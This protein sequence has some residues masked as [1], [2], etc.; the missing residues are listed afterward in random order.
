[1]SHEKPRRQ[2]SLSPPGS[3]GRDSP[4]PD[5]RLSRRAQVDGDDSKRPDKNYRRY[6]AGIERTLTLF[7]ATRL[8]WPDYISFL[9]RL[10]KAIQAHPPGTDTLPHK[11]SVALRLSQCLKPSLPSGVHQKTLEVYS[12]IFALLGTERLGND[13]PTYLPGLSSVLSFASLSLHPTF[14]S[15]IETHIL[16][17]S[18][19]SL[20]PALKALILALLPG[21]E[22]ESSEE[23]ERTIHIVDGLR[24]ASSATPKTNGNRIEGL[25]D[26]FFWQCLF[27][28]TISSRTRRQG[29]L[30]YLNR[31]LPRLVADKDNDLAMAAESVISPEPGLLVRCFVVGLED[32][33]VLIQRGFLDLLLTHLPLDSP[34]LTDRVDAQD[35]KRLVAAAISV[36]ARREMSLNRRLWLWF[37]GPQTNDDDD[38]SAQ[39]ASPITQ[40]SKEQQSPSALY[41]GSYGL[42]PLSDAVLSM[43]TKDKSSPT[44]NARPYRIC[45]SLL[46]RSEIGSPLIARAFVPAMRAAFLYSKAASEADSQEVLRSANSFFDGIESGVIWGQILNLLLQAFETNPSHAGKGVENMQLVKFIL[47]S[48]NVKEEEMLIFHIPLVAVVLLN[49]VNSCTNQEESSQQQTNILIQEALSTVEKMVSYLPERAKLN[50]SF[51]ISDSTVAKGKSAQSKIRAF[52]VEQ[53]GSIAVSPP[54][55]S[56][57]HTARLLLA[58]SSVVFCKGLE[59]HGTSVDVRARILTGLISKIPSQDGLD[60]KTLIKS[61]RDALAFRGEQSR[62]PFTTLTS[63]VQ[64]LSQLSSAQALASDEVGLAAL[65][66]ELVREAWDYLTPSYPRH[67]VEAVRLLWQLD[68]LARGA[69]LV[70]AIVSASLARPSSYYGEKTEMARRFAVIWVHTAQSSSG[71]KNSAWSMRS[72]ITPSDGD[73]QQFLFRPLCLIMDGLN[74][75]DTEL[76]FFL[77]SWL[78][79]ISNVDI[80]LDMILKSVLQLSSELQGQLAGRTSDAAGSLQSHHHDTTSQCLYFLQHLLNVLKLSSSNIWAALSRS[81]SIAIDDPEASEKNITLDVHIARHC[82]RLLRTRPITPDSHPSADDV[83]L[84]CTCLS[85]LQQLMHSTSPQALQNLSLEISLIDTLREYLARGTHESALQIALLDSILASLRLRRPEQPVQQSPLASPVA[86]SVDVSRAPNQLNDRIN[87]SSLSLQIATQPPRQLVDCLQEGIS[88]ASSYYVLEHRIKFL[89][90]VLPLFA[91]SIFQNL[92]PLVECICKQINSNFDQLKTVFIDGAT[93]TRAPPEPSLNA[94]LTGLEHVLAISHEQLAV[95]ESRGHVIKSPEPSQG[96]FGNVV[97]GFS[98]A[99]TQSAGRAA[100][101]TRLTVVLCFQDA[102]RICLSIWS[103]GSV[104][105]ESL[106]KAPHSS[107]SFAYN[108]LRLRN[109]ARRILDR[110]FRAEA[111]EC[112]ETVIATWSNPKADASESALKF[113]HGL[114]STQP[115]VTMP[116]IFNSIYSRTNPS[117]LEPGKLSTLTSDL[118]VPQLGHFL[119][120]Y[121]QSLDDD[122]M[123]EIWTDCMTFLRDLLSNPLPHSAML[124]YL[125]LFLVTLAEKIDNTNFGEQ[126]KIRKELSVRIPNAFLSLSL[127]FCQ[128]LFLRVLAATL[129]TR[130]ALNLSA[131]PKSPGTNGS[132]LGRSRA[133]TI[134]D[135]P[136]LKALDY[137]DLISL[138]IPSLPTILTDQDK[139]VSSCANI[140]AHTINPIMTSKSFPDP[141]RLTHFAL[142]SRISRLPTNPAAKVWKRDISEIF[143]HPKVFSI[144]SSLAQSSLLPLLT[145]WIAGPDAKDRIVDLL[146]RI[147]A[148]TGAGIMFGVGASAARLEADKKTQANLR[149]IAL[150]ILAAPID[151][152]VPQLTE[153]E[154]TIT[155]LLTA[156]ATSSPSSTTRAEV[157]ILLRALLLRTSPLPLAPLWPLLTAELQR[158]IASAVARSPDYETYTVPGLL[159]ACRLLDLLLLLGHDDFQA[160]AWLFVADTVDALYRPSDFEPVG[161]VDDLAE[162]MAGTA[163]PT[164]VASDAVAASVG[165]AA[166]GAEGAD[167]GR[168]V[169]L[170][171]L[172]DGLAVTQL[173]KAQFVKAVLQPFFARLS[174]H[175][176][177]SVYGLGTVDTGIEEEK[178]LRDIFE[179]S[180][181]VG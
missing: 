133:L 152:F 19:S 2:R 176:Y 157:F 77:S 24:N 39:L 88:T 72:G 23:F 135:H 94:L 58:E 63:I 151:T 31:R 141:I 138:V 50:D 129:T 122:A 167:E 162:E 101:N 60:F 164:P 5:A 82:L 64:V 1:M 147:S 107:A 90:D 65:L 153:L 75:H 92:I 47:T 161:L 95:E 80:I 97:A 178:V 59:N 54:P 103:W 124:P 3:S 131:E 20:R 55:F 181:I 69:R 25:G 52:Y 93:V 170:L 32:E 68:E 27:L 125:L 37:L 28:A 130:N 98:A 43:F 71:R 44:K 174:I 179:E 102:V 134:S 48:F 155:S 146:S 136:N 111:L 81:A 105:D 30:A 104:K 73:W 117:A 46:D 40:L 132:A 91:A 137:I 53:C 127:T 85:I 36:V 89:I 74:E 76:K 9:G 49:L 8:E 84:Q 66:P 38:E 12:V 144:P 83:T 26:E 112:L 51:A 16:P 99:G 61:S 22:D 62:L 14:L 140:S 121:T 29:A 172:R 149:R 67:H 18:S 15:V 109:K 123:D 17:L 6:A 4:L 13:L 79:S 42:E 57:Y 163:P 41:F 165:A 156:T 120:E 154:E 177:E 169:A 35:L 126:R 113:L 100:A 70:E 10:L 128:D 158:A 114:D 78:T 45:L 108:S 11:N 175:A 166:A 139:I 33:Q 7:D 34:V 168:R 150:L 160:C 116:T 145:S 171:T 21:L 180:T 115:K 110:V 119:V 86:S 106:R 87:R 159:Q 143:N 142:L 96:F 56:S 148:P 173:D 118:T